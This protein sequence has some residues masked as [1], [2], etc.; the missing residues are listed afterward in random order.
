MREKDGYIFYSYQ[1][2]VTQSQCATRANALDLQSAKRLFVSTLL[3][4]LAAYLALLL[5]SLPP[6]PPLAWGSMTGSISDLSRLIER[7]SP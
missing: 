6:N 1:F 5:L 7:K 2:A 4:S 3:I